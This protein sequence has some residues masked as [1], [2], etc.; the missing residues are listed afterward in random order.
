MGLYGLIPIS[1][2]IP[3]MGLNGLSRAQPVSQLVT[4]LHCYRVVLVGPKA[5]FGI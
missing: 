5:T 3:H 4:L 2:Y 1:T